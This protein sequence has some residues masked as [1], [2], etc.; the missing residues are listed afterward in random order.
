MLTEGLTTNRVLLSG[1]FITEDRDVPYDGRSQ[2]EN[3]L[4]ERTQ[5]RVWQLSADVRVTTKFGVQVTATV[6]D[7]TRSAVVTRASGEV[8]NFSENFSGIGDT[9]VI[10]WRRLAVR[11][12]WN[13]TLNGGVSLPTGK[14]ERPK[15]REE[16][17]EGSLVPMSRLQRGS[18]T[19]DPLVG[20]SA[21]RLFAGILSPGVRLFASAAARVPVAEN[22]FGLRTGASWEIGA[23]GSRELRQAGFGH[24]V[25]GIVRVS[26]LHR[27]QDVFE[28][29]PVLVGGGNWITVSPGLAAAFGAWTVQGEI[30]VP[31]WRS[32]ANRQLDSSWLAQLGLVRSF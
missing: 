14:A 8:V 6:P 28:G 9:T 32:L 26:W 30:K 13:V 27:N 7:V 18:G 12:G 4:R 15:F 19:F 29:T 31:I 10:A 22:E 23:G 3:P 2:T 21:N 24:N 17:S 5:I 11:R 16:L 20:F 25:I 1:W